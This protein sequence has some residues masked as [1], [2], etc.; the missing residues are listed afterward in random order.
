MLIERW[1]NPGNN[2]IIKKSNVTKRE[3][4]FK[5][6]EDNGNAMRYTDIIKFAYE[7]TYGKNSSTDIQNWVTAF[8]DGVEIENMSKGESETV[9]E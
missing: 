1:N 5:Y 9:S 8:E 3:K 4:I 6:I 2:S 7:D